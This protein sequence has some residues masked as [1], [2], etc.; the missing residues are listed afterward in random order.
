M[1][2]AYFLC[3]TD[4]S[5]QFHS[6]PI[7]YHLQTHWFYYLS[8]LTHPLNSSNFLHHFQ[9]IQHRY[10]CTGRIYSRDSLSSISK[11]SFYI[12]SSFTV[13]RPSIYAA[14]SLIKLTFDCKSAIWEFSKSKL[15][16]GWV[17][18][19]ICPIKP[20]T[21]RSVAWIW[22]KRERYKERS[23]SSITML[24]SRPAMTFSSAGR[25]DQE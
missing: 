25:V 18:F 1:L 10:V 5:H 11:Y 9:P 16:E 21:L 19:P 15:T 20:V 23:L 24:S 3:K 22:D 6:N 7:E 14:D 13:W 12:T 17:I 4:L 2:L 8:D